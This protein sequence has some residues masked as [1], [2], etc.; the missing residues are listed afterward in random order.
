MDTF[1]KWWN[2]PKADDKSILA[3]FYYA[4]KALTAVASELDSFDGRAE[5]ERCSRLVG[6]LRQG[7]DQVLAIT[8]IIMDELL[9]EDRAPR[10]FRAKFPEEVL[11]ESLA[12]QLWFGAECLAA[13]S[14][15]M[16]RETESAQMRPLA[17][18]VTKSLDHVRNLLREQC[19]RNKTPNSLTLN[20]D[21]NDAVTETL[22][23]SLKIFDRLFAEF[24]LLYVSA[25]V[26]VKSKQEHEMQ[27]LICVLFS[28]TLQ[29]ALRIG[30][31]EQEQVDYY[32]P[33]LMFSIPRLAI[34]AG[35]VIYNKGPL[36][37]SMPA[38]QLSEMFRP[39]RTLLIKIRDLLR[40]LNANE[41]YQLEK[42]LCTNED[43]HIYTSTQESNPNDSVVSD[44]MSTTIT[45]PT[46]DTTETI[47]TTTTAPPTPALPTSEIANFNCDDSDD[48]EKFIG[49]NSSASSTSSESTTST[50]SR[51][52]SN[53]SQSTSTGSNSTLEI[54][55]AIETDFDRRFSSNRSNNISTTM[56]NDNELAP[57]HIVNVWSNA[58]YSNAEA[59]STSL[60]VDSTIDSDSSTNRNKNEWISTECASG[61]L[62]PNTNFGNL[63]QTTDTPLTD[64]FISSDDEYTQKNLTTVTENDDPMYVVGSTSMD[65]MDSEA[66]MAVIQSM[67][68]NVRVSNEPNHMQTIPGV[69]SDISRMAMKH[70]T[71]CGG[72]SGIG[73]AENTSLDHTPDSEMNKLVDSTTT[74]DV[75]ITNNVPSRSQ[76]QQQ[77]EH[78]QQQRIENSFGMYG[79]ET[80]TPNTSEIYNPNTLY[81]NYA[82]PTYYHSQEHGAEQQYDEVSLPMPPQH[83][84][85]LHS[86]QQNHSQSQQ[87]RRS[88]RYERKS[89]PK[90]NSSH[91]SSSKTSSGN[92]RKRLARRRT[93]RNTEEKV[94]IS[95]TSCIYSEGDPQ[96]VW[97]S[98][99]RMKFKSTENLL[100]RLFV[101]IA[102]VADQLQTNFASDLRQILR[103]VFLMN[104][105]PPPIEDIEIDISGKSKDSTSDLFEFRASENDVIHENDGGSNQS[106][107]S[108][109]EANPENDSVFEQSIVQSLPPGSD[110]QERS[111]S[112][113][114]EIR[115]THSRVNVE[116]SQ[117]LSDDS[118]TR[119][120]SLVVNT[121]HQIQCVERN[122]NHTEINDNSP[123]TNVPRLMANVNNNNANVNNN[124]TSR[125]VDNSS[126]M[127]TTT[128]TIILTTNSRLNRNDQQSQPQQQITETPPRWIPDE[129]AAQC[130]S[131]SQTFT[132]FRR[133]H[134]C[135]CC[136][137]VF[138]GICSNSQAPLP[139]FGLN[140][141]VRVCRN[142]F[143]MNITGTQSAHT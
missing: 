88:D 81:Q 121:T 51:T 15:I 36:N 132:T 2:K 71:N 115:I 104:V 9:G 17:K 128:T 14:S 70:T 134:H 47:T 53:S 12:G 118:S 46:T 33:A 18:A 10:T 116:R 7:Q 102:G 56:I 49:S 96:D 35:L 69:A 89:C 139:K 66:D 108:A 85:R 60:L 30:L 50:V 125:S 120:V 119:P 11:Q 112:L 114:T 57:N 73:T 82:T 21:L 101:C 13:G 77:N 28:E 142:C 110:H 143:S 126:T 84:T 62:I 42:L 43:I 1:R 78:E 97:H 141:A 90:T 63:L 16:N 55:S 106:I 103:S 105:S 107:Y 5:P 75:T 65:T 133:R 24:E 87:S 41:L 122:G 117:S 92:T 34:V 137:G 39:F 74:N 98:S 37:M 25:M 100:H 86:S 64:S 40:T 29:R 72:D 93:T 52:S 83:H 48:E 129:E 138:C 95:S 79:N 68:D 109:E 113:E 23:E 111:A 61:Y 32:D 76:Q 127:A 58:P 8:N 20:L 94:S 131:C 4:D 6:R 45:T 80:N 22:C 19:L 44:E 3:R 136:G 124:Q 38:D 54:P 26:Q 135:R 123:Q 67:M 99:G 31:L 27:E 91:S 130:M 59:S 140:K